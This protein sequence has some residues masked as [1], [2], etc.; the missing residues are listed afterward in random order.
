MGAATRSRRRSNGSGALLVERGWKHAP[1]EGE[2]GYT[3]YER[4]PV[5][6]ELAFLD[7]DEHREVYTPLQQGRG[8]WPPGSFEHD[9]AGLRGV[10]ARVVSLRSLKAEKAENRDDPVVAAKDRADSATLS[11]ILEMSR[12]KRIGA[13]LT[14]EVEFKGKR[15]SVRFSV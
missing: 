7:R 5:R 3:V 9:V 6:L 4:G 10:R 14:S 1:E 12:L 13:D 2:D 15:G 8:A 11:R